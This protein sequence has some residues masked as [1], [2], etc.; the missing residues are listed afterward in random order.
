VIQLT[1]P[2]TRQDCP[3]LICCRFIVDLQ[4][5]AVGWAV[6]KK[7]AETDTRGTNGWRLPTSRP[8]QSVSALTFA[9]C[10][11][12]CY[13]DSFLA[14]GVCVKG[15][16]RTAN[17]AFQIL[18]SSNASDKGNAGCRA[19]AI[20][21]DRHSPYFSGRSPDP[22][23]HAQHRTGRPCLPPS[24]A[25]RPAM[26]DHL[27][28]P[29]GHRHGDGD[30]RENDLGRGHADDNVDETKGEGCDNIAD[31]LCECSRPSRF[32]DP[33]NRWESR[34]FLFSRPF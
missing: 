1:E 29:D 33:T 23:P 4:W 28:F 11:A 24:F 34:C 6:S 9:S 12:Y 26:Y 18:F 30:C 3:C 7:N 5:S 15:P 2:D 16:R 20:R 21:L 13:R 31:R 27:V 8:L 14:S 10:L 17:S 22:W 25:V 32:V 19:L